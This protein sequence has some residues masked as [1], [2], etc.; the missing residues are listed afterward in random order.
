MNISGEGTGHIDATERHMAAR[1]KKLRMERGLSQSKVDD[2]AGHPVGTCKMLEQGTT[3]F[4]PSQ[5]YA[6][7]EAFGVVTSFF[8]VGL[9]SNAAATTVEFVSPHFPT[10]THE[11]KELIETFL[12]IRDPGLRKTIIELLQAAADD[13]HLAS[14]ILPFL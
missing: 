2:M 5:L 12:N 14:N 11:T 7:A 6:L 13:P 9:P 10:M 8:F 1:L 4:G 3:F